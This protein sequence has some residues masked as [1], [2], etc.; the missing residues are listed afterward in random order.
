MTDAQEWKTQEINGLWAVLRDPQ[1]T[2][3]GDPKA[4]LVFCCRN[5]DGHLVEVS[6]GNV[7]PLDSAS[8]DNARFIAE[9]MGISAVITEPLIGRIVNLARDLK[10]S[11]KAQVSSDESA[12]TRTGERRLTPVVTRLSDV[13]PEIISWL[14]EPYI[15]LGKLTLLDGDPGVGKSVLCACIAAIVTRGLA[16]PSISP[17]FKTPG[18]DAA[19]VLYIGVED[20]LGDTMRPR[21]DAAGGDP[22]KFFA[23]RAAKDESGEFA[24]VSLKDLG[25][26]KALLEA[27]KPS[28]MFIDPLQGYLGDKVNPNLS[29]DIN[30]VLH[31]IAQMAEE[32]NCAIVGIRHLNKGGS[33]EKALYRGQNSIA[34]IGVAR[35]GLLVGVDPED[36]NRK[37]I[38]HQKHNV[39]ARGTSLAYRIIEEPVEYED[40]VIGAPRVRWDGE[41]PLT[42]DDLCAPPAKAG[43]DEEFA[44]DSAR[45][46]LRDL[47]AKE[48]VQF[49]DIKEAAKKAGHAWRT[50]ERAKALLGVASRRDD[51]QGGPYAKRP[52]VWFLPDKP[53]ASEGQKQAPPGPGCFTPPV[54][55]P[56]SPPPESP[57]SGGVAVYY[58]AIENAEVMDSSIGRHVAAYG[59]SDKH[60]KNNDLPIDRHTATSQTLGGGLSG[61]LSVKHSQNG[62]SA[63]LSCARCKTSINV[64]A[65]TGLCGY[66]GAA[67]VEG[68]DHA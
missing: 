28:V 55:P 63:G 66:C 12:K 4:E 44:R 21:L 35:S 52:W 67:G 17:D 7:Y 59:E 64:S 37:I 1:K 65:V 19:N 3:S 56:P 42:A 2:R 43:E 11:L 18:R 54:T 5:D 32:S 33:A 49:A 6:G 58:Q 26:F 23:V 36:P 20:G 25:F 57:N 9:Q 30:A 51:T 8:I 34:F 10:S 22:E 27:Y 68:G 14:W 41:S 48:P 40:R 61:G 39:S 31:P 60:I 29:S 16:F 62:Q 38:A 53:D 13:Q 45:S 50:V 47:L 24:S 46:F 15:P